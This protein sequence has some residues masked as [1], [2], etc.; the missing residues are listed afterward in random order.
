MDIFTQKGSDIYVDMT[1]FFRKVHDYDGQ[2]TL[3]E[4]LGAGPDG[5]ARP[6][7]PLL[8][9]IDGPFARAVTSGEHE[10]GVMECG[11]SSYRLPPSFHVPNGQRGEV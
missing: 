11:S 8:P 5:S 10:G 9:R 1:G 3:N 7:G 2:F 4:A 6:Q